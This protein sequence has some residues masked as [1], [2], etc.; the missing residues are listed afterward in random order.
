MIACGGD[1]IGFEK[2]RPLVMIG[3]PCGDMLHSKFAICLWGTGRGAKDH[4]QGLAT[5]HSSIVAHAREQCVNAALEAKADYLMFLDS[6]MLFPMNTI[7]RLLAH[8][9]DVVCASYIRRGPPFDPMGHP[10]KDE[11]RTAKSGLI[12]MTHVPLGVCLIKMSIFS[13]LARPFFRYETDLKNAHVR[14]ED[15]V[16]SEMVRASGVELWCDVDLSREIGHIYNYVL[17]IPD[18]A[19]K[20]VG[21]NYAGAANG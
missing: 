9:K 2:K 7:D 10:V 8:K 17:Q 5:G 19:V 11:D 15:F 12:K 4:R 18:E 14:G 3:V 20:E 21:K 13:A 16:F 1:L 6:D